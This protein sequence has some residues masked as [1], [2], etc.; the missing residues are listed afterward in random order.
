M[1]HHDIQL[2]GHT[3][4]HVDNNHNQNHNN[5]LDKNDSNTNND[6]HQIYSNI[7]TIS[8]TMVL[9]PISLPPGP[10]DLGASKPPK[11]CS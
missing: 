6:Y 7:I 8:V 11:C 2:K 5:T 10:N 1:K 3:M 4:K 9:V